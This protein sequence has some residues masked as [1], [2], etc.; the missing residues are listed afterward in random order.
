MTNNEILKALKNKGDVSNFARF[1]NMSTRGI[2]KLLNNPKP[3]SNQYYNFMQFI[4]TQYL[5]K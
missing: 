4:K 1:L 5:N 3:Q 2:Y